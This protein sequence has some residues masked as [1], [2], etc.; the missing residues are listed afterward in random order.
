MGW[1]CLLSRARTHSLRVAGNGLT[2]R[3]FFF[4]RRQRAGHGARP[5]GR[6]EPVARRGASPARPGPQDGGG[7]RGAGRGGAV[8]LAAAPP[9][10]PRGGARVGRRAAAMASGCRIGP[11]ILN[12]DL[13]ALG[14]ECSRMLD[15]GADYLHL[16]V[17]DG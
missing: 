2:L 10:R 9:G 3:A 12:S 4:P 16:D 11:S 5:L 14:A 17:M 6:G 15:C 1:V 8:A 13:A 7:R